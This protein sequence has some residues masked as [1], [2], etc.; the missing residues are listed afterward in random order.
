MCSIQGLG[1]Q[2]ILM[3][4]V[5]SQMLLPPIT[6]SL[7]PTRVSKFPPGAYLDPEIIQ[8]VAS[9]CPGNG[10]VSFRDGPPLFLLSCV[11]APGPV[12][13]RLQARRTGR[14]P[15]GGICRNKGY[16]SGWTS[17]SQEGRSF[18]KC[19]SSLEYTYSNSK[20]VNRVRTE[21]NPSSNLPSYYFPVGGTPLRDGSGFNNR[22]CVFVRRPIPLGRRKYK[23]EHEAHF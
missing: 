21:Q 17:I 10:M 4:T 13:C 5:A 6:A 9:F 15:I 18:I 12:Q 16:L 7:P 14:Q 20:C 23:E 1:I 11:P 22:Y 2:V 8:P 19:C 3:V